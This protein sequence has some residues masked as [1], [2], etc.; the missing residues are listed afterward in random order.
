MKISLVAAG[1]AAAIAMSP[2]LARAQDDAPQE[3]PDTLPPLPPTAPAREYT[4]PLAQKTQPSYVPQSVALSGP[5]VITDWEEGEAVPPGYHVSTRIRRGPVIAG[6]V[7]FGVLYLLSTLVAAEAK[8][9]YHNENALFI[10]AVGPFVQMG[11]TTD[12]GGLWLLAVDGLA[13][14]AG[15]GMFVYGVASP[16]QVLVRNDLGFQIAPRPMMLGRDGSGFG[17]VGSF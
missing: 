13:Q 7:V 3:A 6:A 4:A 8:D 1:M 9:N 14:T 16:K 2:G 15:I 10:P 11:S 17:V 12:G 5:R